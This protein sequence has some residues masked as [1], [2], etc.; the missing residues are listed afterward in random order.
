MS[1]HVNENLLGAENIE[2]QPQRRGAR[3]TLNGALWALQGLFGFFFAGS[4]FGKVLLYDGALYAAAPRAVAWYAA[5][6]Q[7]LIVFIGVCEV[8]GGVGLI[9]PAMTGVK[10]KLT[11]LAA[12]GLTLTMILAAGFHIMR[13]EY[14]LVPANILLGGVSAY[15]AVGRWKLRPV[16]PATITTSGVLK[17]LAVLG[18]LALLGF[19]PTWYTM[20]HA[21]F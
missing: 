20:T 5:V 4:G 14:A 16:A 3:F 19:A 13:G 21:A 9:L 18:A 7:P 2:R 6:P 1:Q 15:I 12:A 17:S 8:L 10:P 11:P